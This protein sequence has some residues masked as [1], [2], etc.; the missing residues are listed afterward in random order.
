M[1]W[2]S[3]SPERVLRRGYVPLGSPTSARRSISSP[4]ICSS[5]CSARVSR[6]AIARAS[7]ASR[8]RMS[9]ARACRPAS[10][11]AS[12]ERRRSCLDRALDTGREALGTAAELQ[13]GRM[14][15]YIADLRQRLRKWYGSDPKVEDF[16]GQASEMLGSL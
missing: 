6:S 11:M 12:S 8:R 14:V 15:R 1:L 13:S 16:D 5:S 3:A 4:A 2:L 9:R 10:V 7:Q